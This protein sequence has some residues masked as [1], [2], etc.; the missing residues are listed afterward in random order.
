[1]GLPVPPPS[2]PRRPLAAAGFVRHDWAILAAV[3][4]LLLAAGV[5]LLLQRRW[6]M[7]AWALLKVLLGL[8]AALAM[9]VAMSWMAAAD[10]G[11]SRLRRAAG[12]LLVLLAGA[13]V[14]AVVGTALAAGAGYAALGQ[15]RGMFLGAGFGGM[16]A[17]VSRRALGE[18]RH[19]MAFRRLL[20]AMLGSLFLSLLA[21]MLPWAWGV[22][23]AIL[24]PLAVFAIL[25]A[26]G[27][28]LPPP[29]P[30]SGAS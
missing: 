16:A 3:A 2:Q 26:A 4:L 6:E 14:G 18:P 9:L 28:L 23:A 17:L 15:D 13:A 8:A 21:L 10:P 30:L 24:L 27:R 25:A 11:S 19:W 20:L 29:G 22:D 5:P 7:A 12:M 1:M